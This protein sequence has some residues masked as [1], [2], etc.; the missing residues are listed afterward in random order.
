MYNPHRKTQKQLWSIKKSFTPLCKS[1]RSTST[2]PHSPALDLERKLDEMLTQKIETTQT[3]RKD[4]CRQMVLD[5]DPFAPEIMMFVDMMKLYA[6]PDAVM[7]RSFPPTLRREARD[8]VA[9]L[10]PRSVRNFDQLSQSFVAY[11]LNSKR[12][13]K[14]AIGLMQVI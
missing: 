11:F 6:A 13:R 12:K 14:T 2:P 8:W 1:C 7:S 10:A 9:T 5:E 4:K 3:K